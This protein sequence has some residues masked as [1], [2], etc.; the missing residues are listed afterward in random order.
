MFKAQKK[1]S[2]KG[3]QQG[4]NSI[5]LNN[6]KVQWPDDSLNTTKCTKSFKIDLIKE[7]NRKNKEDSTL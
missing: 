2:K 4:R 1:A 3:L 5:K 6:N 7:R